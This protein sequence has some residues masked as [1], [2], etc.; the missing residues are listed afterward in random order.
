MRAGAARARALIAQVLQF[1]IAG[2]PVLPVDLDALRFRDG[3]MF[4]VGAD[5]VRHWSIKKAFDVAHAGDAAHGRDQL[6]ELFLILHVNRHFDQRPCCVAIHLGLG[7]Q[8]PDI[9]VLGRE[10]GREL[11]QHPGAVVGVDHD[12]YG[13]RLGC[14]PGPL[15]VDLALDVVHKA[16]DIGA[17]PGVHGD[18][19]TPGHVSDDGFAAN[20]IAALRAIDQQIIQSFDADDRIGVLVR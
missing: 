17:H 20:R 2:V 4:G 18:T 9:G 14:V 5:Q 10:H 19:L 15:D 16:L 1:V 12:F 3:D 13:E 6:F 11:I 7:F 8:A